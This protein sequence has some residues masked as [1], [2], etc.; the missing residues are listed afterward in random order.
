MS[1]ALLV[2]DHGSRRSQANQQLATIVQLL[3][4][5]RP[6]QLIALAHME[7]AAPNIPQAIESLISEGARELV[8]L[9]YFLSDGRHCR[10]DIPRLVG[11]AIA[12]HGNMPWRIGRALG[13]HRRLAELLLEQ[14]DLAATLQ[15]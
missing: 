10:E 14:A 7:I 3:R 9:P 1:Q 5:L 13:P 2:V 15:S 4:E 8:V 12:A 11:E 6:Q